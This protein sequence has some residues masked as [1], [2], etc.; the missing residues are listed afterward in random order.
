MAGRPNERDRV[1]CLA[2]EDLIYADYGGS[3]S[4]FGDRERLVTD[5]SIAVDEWHAAFTETLN[6]IDEAI[7]MASHY[8]FI[9]DGSRGLMQ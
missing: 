7:A 6:M 2:F 5:R 1:I 4:E 3:G 8:V 9:R